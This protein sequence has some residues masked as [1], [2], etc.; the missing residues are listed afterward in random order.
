MVPPITLYFPSLV[1]VQQD[2]TTEMNNMD[3][4]GH[5]SRQTVNYDQKHLETVTGVNQQKINECF[6]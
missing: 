6:S 2:D 4:I 3:N 5:H 1:Q